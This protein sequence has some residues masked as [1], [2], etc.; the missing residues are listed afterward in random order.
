MRA[1]S[2]FRSQAYV[3]RML[4][5]TIRI[6]RQ[7][8]VSAVDILPGCGPTPK[9]VIQGRRPALVSEAMWTSCRH[10]VRFFWDRDK[11]QSRSCALAQKGWKMAGATSRFRAR[12]G[13]VVDYLEGDPTSPS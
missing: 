5:V 10:R 12:N 1:N 7:L 8:R 13:V 4:L 11:A 3:Q 2:C 6:L 9:P